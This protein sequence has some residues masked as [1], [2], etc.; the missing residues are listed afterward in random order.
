MKKLL[1]SLLALI[2]L[3]GLA[4]V[5]AEEA[6]ASYTTNA[7]GEA[8]PAPAGYRVSRVLTGEMMGAGRLN[9]PLDLFYH[10]ASG[11]I[12]LADTGNSRVL[13]L[14]SALQYLREYTAAGDT[15]FVT[16]SGVFVDRTGEVYVADEGAG[17]V[18]RFT[19]DGALVR[20]Y[21]R[22]VSE[23]Y[24]EGTPYRPQKV[25]VDSAGRVYVLSAGVYQ[26]LLSYYEDGSFLNYFGASHVD[27]TAK[28]L[29]QKLW[30]SP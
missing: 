21:T 25:V 27:V 12:W 5:S 2:F 10:E 7:W 8:V 11:E 15:P 29:L 24:E 13:V 1:L 16:P 18:L 19:Q 23:L 3:L 20:A 17:A 4:P 14:D 28:V 6:Y 9:K 26:G 22:P 30:R